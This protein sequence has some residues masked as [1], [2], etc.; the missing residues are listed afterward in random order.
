M[1]LERTRDARPKIRPFGPDM[2]RQISIREVGPRDGL[3]REAPL[4]VTKRLSLIQ[5]LVGCGLSAIE[6]ASF[7][8][9]RSVP[10]MA[11]ASELAAGLPTLSLIHI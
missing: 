6:V 5:A 2:E 1:M 7:V 9:E 3:Q 11:G 10:A 8:S 4:D